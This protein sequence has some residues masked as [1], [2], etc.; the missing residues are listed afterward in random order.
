MQSSPA[1]SNPLHIAVSKS[2]GVSIDWSDGHKSVFTNEYLRDEC[3]CASCT[4]AHGT[5]P[6][7]SNYAAEA[8]AASPAANPFQMFKPKLRMDSI[9]EVGSYAIRIYWNDGH[10]SGIYS[11]DHL[12]SICPCQECK[13]AT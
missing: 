11:F 13:S 12:R 2:R 7:R 3:P 8:R 5:E 4:G 9:E 1:S 10:N 6:Q